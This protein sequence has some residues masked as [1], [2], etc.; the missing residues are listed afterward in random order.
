MLKCFFI[1]ALDVKSVG[2]TVRSVTPAAGQSLTLYCDHNDAIDWRLNDFDRLYTAGRIHD[3]YHA[4]ISVTTE[5]ERH[6]LKLSFESYN[7][8]DRYMCSD[9]NDGEVIKVYVFVAG[10]F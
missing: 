3:Y 8:G 7:D 1:A 2:L 6:Y 4:N 9:A 10:E 5:G